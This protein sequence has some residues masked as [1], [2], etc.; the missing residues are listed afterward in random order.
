MFS[1]LLL[2]PWGCLE[3]MLA[4]LPC[5]SLKS[6]SPQTFLEHVFLRE[7]KLLRMLFCSVCV[8]LLVSHSFHTDD[9][10]MTSRNPEYPSCVTYSCEGAC[11]RENTQGRHRWKTQ[12]E[13][14]PGIVAEVLRVC[15]N[16][17]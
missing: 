6:V 17:P 4:R 11:V 2:T 9:S 15:E 12:T 8:S 1:L 5:R 10:P 13:A 16:F 3:E 7:E 14:W